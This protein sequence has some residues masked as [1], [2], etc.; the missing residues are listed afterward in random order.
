MFKSRPRIAQ[1]P[2]S[3]PAVH[4]SPLGDFDLHGA[5]AAE[6]DMDQEGFE[7]YSELGLDSPSVRKR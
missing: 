4:V 1:S 7:G 6:K 3:S 5:G 2:V